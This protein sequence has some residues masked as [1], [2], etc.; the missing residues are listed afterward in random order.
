MGSAALSQP[1]G[2]LGVGSGRGHAAQCSG[3]RAETLSALRGV[4]PWIG[5][6]AALAIPA[7]TPGQSVSRTRPSP[8]VDLGLWADNGRS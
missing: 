4:L 2:A 3:Q 6:V 7:A 8:S 5:I 1:L